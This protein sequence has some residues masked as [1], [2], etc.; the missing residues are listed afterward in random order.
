MTLPPLPAREPDAFDAPE[1]IA[2][3]RFAV[4]RSLYGDCY[5]QKTP[6]PWRDV[7][8]DCGL[9]RDCAISVLSSLRSILQS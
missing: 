5:C 9:V 4:C 8:A 6:P 2:Q 7:D 1:T 3:A